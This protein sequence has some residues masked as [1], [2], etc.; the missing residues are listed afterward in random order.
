M[1]REPDGPAAGTDRPS[2]RAALRHSLLAAR[3]QG[4][5]IHTGSR[6]Q[7]LMDR[8]HRRVLQEIGAL[9]RCR[10]AVYWPIRGE[11][12]LRPLWQRWSELGAILA[13]PV[14]EASARPL[15]FVRWRPDETMRIGNYGIPQPIELRD[16]E[17]QLIVVPCV[18]FDA[19]CHRLGYGGGFYDRT[20][21]DWRSRGLGC[22]R[23]WGV[24]WDDARIDGFEAQPTD[25]ALDAVITPNAVIT[26]D[27]VSV[28]VRS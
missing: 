10:I 19:Q 17:P 15:R 24:A 21:A 28:S 18:G 16:L 27:G 20:L 22:G 23:A 26:P 9:H 5:V 25:I 4:L 1:V 12:D 13:L 7:A 3:A 14:V 8:L 11:P 6:A 2:G